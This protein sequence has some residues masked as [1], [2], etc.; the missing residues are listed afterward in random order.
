MS[1]RI[2]L[3]IIVLSVIG[4]LATGWF[5]RGWYEGSQEKKRL[6]TA[7][8]AANA[9]AEEIKKIQQKNTVIEHKVIYDTFTVPVYKEC[10]HSPESYKSILELFK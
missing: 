9:A 6:E 3:A 4:L 2:K 1:E 7:T 10:K 5:V 8:I